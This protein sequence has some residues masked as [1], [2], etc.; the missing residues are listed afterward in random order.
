MWTR[1]K[2][3]MIIFYGY[4]GY[5]GEI[6]IDTLTQNTNGWKL[7]EKKC[8]KILGKT[9]KMIKNNNNNN[10]TYIKVILTKN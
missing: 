10:N 1:M 6:S 2:I 5:I 9:Q 8:I 7:I 3:S 4:I